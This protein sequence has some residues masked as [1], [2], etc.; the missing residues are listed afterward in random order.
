MGSVD[1]DY[2]SD[3]V[4]QRSISE[5]FGAELAIGPALALAVGQ[6]PSSGY[7]QTLLS[8]AMVVLVFSSVFRFLAFTDRF[9]DPERVSRLTVRPL[10]ISAIICLVQIVQFASIELSAFVPSIETVGLSLLITLLG[11]VLFILG[12]ESV[13]QT[14]RFSWGVLY[15]VKVVSI[16]QSIGMDLD[17]ID[18]VSEFIN[19]ED[20]I[21]NSMKTAVSLL[22]FQVLRAVYV[23]VAY[24]LL[25][26]SI[27]EE[28]DNPYIDELQTWV[29]AHRDQKPISD[30]ASI[31]FA[32]G[33]S[34]MVVFPV[35]FVLSWTLSWIL[36]PVLTVLGVVV[37]MRL[38]QHVVN[39]AY[40]SF[41]GLRYDQVLTTNARSVAID[42]MY[43]LVVWVMLVWLPFG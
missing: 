6:I 24:F 12:Y 14:Y 29:N 32:L 35:Y 28:E 18:A 30:R 17:D 2:V 4:F 11:T 5:Q 31:G 43:T 8:V 38:L 21:W 15:Y 39:V 3:I 13:F 36:G 34:G 27:P 20:S 9:A 26:D 7:R 10:Q 40:I 1:G 41:G 42:A 33:I 19:S 23:S 25:R 37:V 22:L 16:N